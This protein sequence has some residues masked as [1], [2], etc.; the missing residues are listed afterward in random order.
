M[1][2]W[3]RVTCSA[4]VVLV[5]C[6][7]NA[8][9]QAGLATLSISVTLPDGAAATGARV[10]V[11][12]PGA[13]AIR[14]AVVDAAHPI[15]MLPVASGPHRIRVELA[16][17]RA[18]EETQNLDPGSE[19]RLA[20]RLAPEGGMGRSTISI[21][22]RSEPTYQTNLGAEWLSDLPSGRTAWSLLDT[23]HPFVITD[24]MDNGG[25]WSA[26]AA[27]LGGS[28]PSWN[29]TQFRLDG[30]DVTDTRDGGAPAIYPDLGLFDAVQVETARLGVDT[31]GPGLAIS[32]IPKHPG[33]VWSGSGEAF[34]T[35]GSWQP[36]PE[37]GI[38]PPLGRYDHWTDASLSASGPMTGRTGLFASIR[39][40][41]G[42]RFERGDPLELSNN[43]ASLYGHLVGTAGTDRE[44]RVTTALSRAT[45][46]FEGRA[47]YANR[48]IDE[49]GRTVLGQ[50]A[51]EQ[52]R[53]G[54]LLAVSGGFHRVS[55]EPQVTANSQ[56]ANIERLLDGPPR[57]LGDAADTISQRWTLAAS[58]APAP[59]RWLRE[60][61][62]LRVGATVSGARVTNKA[63]FQPVFG[64]LVDGVPAR[65]WDI[66]YKG[67]RSKWAS[68]AVNAFAS[69]RWELTP[70]FTVNAGVRFDHDSGSAEGA[71]NGIG[72]TTALPRFTLRWAP[73]ENSP[74]TVTAGYSWYRDRLPLNYLSVGDPN[75]PTGTV[76]RWDD[77]NG[78]FFFAPSEVTP[79][80]YIGSCCANNVASVIAADLK[81]PYAAEFF[82]GA[83]HR[84]GAWRMRMTGV[85]RREHR[86]TAL[87]NTGI[88]LSDYVAL[89]VGDSG[90]DV[91]GNTTAQTLRLYGRTPGMLGRDRYTLTDLDGLTAVYQ[92]VDITVDREL[93][94]R[95]FFRFG[96]SAYRIESTGAS[97][98][99]QSGENDQGLLG[100][101]FLWPNAF[102]SAEGRSFFDRA[103]VIKLSG[104]YRAPGDVRVGLVARYQD[105][106]PFSR[107]V[108]ADGFTQGRDLVMAIPR[109]DQRFTYMF[110]LDA[111]VEKDVTFGRR[112][113]GIIFEAYNLTD[114]T[115]EAEE[116]VVT[117]HAFRTVSAVQ[118]PLAVRV[119]LRVG[120]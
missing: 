2:F 46:P 103:F 41:N 108:V 63:L 10:E 38:A 120:F 59:G 25:L 56:G 74:L 67:V 66:R 90:I 80:A 95:W 15:A 45:R 68:T 109:G 70:R 7:V 88:P 4:L 19:R 42:S 77:R 73:R 24:R 65:V 58:L 114:A 115:I 87:V 48:D 101:A 53:G 14:T 44:L 23:A 60:S 118:P 34:V 50:A 105:G 43:I 27:K 89:D 51:V 107:M 31:A 110:T 86:L 61:H 1:S 8:A 104:A 97:R 52:V 116:Y 93:F 13:G 20:V 119:G 33:E 18:A 69:D 96:G 5:A 16:G 12:P 64:E 72:W 78:D 71:A 81:A 57:S 49:R 92:G 84:M 32:L 85:D 75:G 30:L 9:A 40:T 28:G 39:G 91:D 83:E 99:F 36:D 3:R 17:Y 37:P 11:A 26:R 76:S 82:I 55:N 94:R 6:A 62:Q 111:K 98:G 47:R 29:Q 22:S 100:E 54:Q 21:V 35:P 112:Q 79:I 113:V 117:G 106:L 102:T